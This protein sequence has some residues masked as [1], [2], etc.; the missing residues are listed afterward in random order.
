MRAANCFE[1]CKEGEFHRLG[2]PLESGLY[3]I[4]DFR[5]QMDMWHQELVH[6]RWYV[7]NL[8]GAGLLSCCTVP[9]M[10]RW[11]KGL[12]SAI[13][14]DLGF[15]FLPALD[16]LPMDGIPSAVLKHELPPVKSR[17][18]RLLRELDAVSQ[19][20]APKIETEYELMRRG[21]PRLEPLLERAMNLADS[22][23]QLETSSRPFMGSC[24]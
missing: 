10:P 11:I 19:A 17:A 1:S 16:A 2:Y 4:H 20:L 22:T 14:Y 24:E 7:A 12:P 13:A 18:F 6:I 3:K 8:G 9:E 23:I 15:K 21:R 5:D